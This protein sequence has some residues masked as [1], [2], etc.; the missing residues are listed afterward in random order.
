[1]DTLPEKNAK[2]WV[3]SLNTWR[4]GTVRSVEP[5][6]STLVVRVQGVG[7]RYDTFVA[8][9]NVWPWHADDTTEQLDALQKASNESR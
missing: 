7:R 3:R 8:V 4:T 1:M 5:K 6:H 9:R 2:V